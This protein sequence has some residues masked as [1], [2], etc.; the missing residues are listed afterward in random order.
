MTPGRE[1]RMRV[2]CFRI[3]SAAP[4]ISST[5]SPLARRASSKSAICSSPHR[6]CMIWS[7]TSDISSRLRCMPPRRRSTKSEMLMRQV[8]RNRRPSWRLLCHVPCQTAS[9]P[10]K[11]QLV[12]THI[13]RTPTCLSGRWIV[14]SATQGGRGR[15]RWTSRCG[16]GPLIPTRR[17]SAAEDWPLVVGRSAWDAYGFIQQSR[18]AL[19]G[20]NSA[21]SLVDDSLI[22]LLVRLRVL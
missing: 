21:G 15:S 13:S 5:V 10:G 2:M 8:L 19:I 9:V 6:P 11:R 18:T 22:D 4:A 14:A 17:P 12:S 7:T 16:R 3:A 1:V 20:Q